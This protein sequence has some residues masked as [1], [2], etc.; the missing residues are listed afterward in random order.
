M[1]QFI[2]A[3][4]GRTHIVHNNDLDTLERGILE[5]VI[6]RKVDNELLPPMEPLIDVMSAGRKFRE[7]CCKRIS[8]L[9]PWTH[10][11]VVDAMG[12]K[13]KTYQHHLDNLKLR[14]LTRSDAKQT[15]F[16]KA[17]PLDLKFKVVEDLKPRIIRT[18]TVEFHISLGAYI[19]SCEKKI[20]GAINHVCGGIT[21]T[22]GLNAEETAEAIVAAFNSF[23]NPVCI[24]LDA[25][26]A[27]QSFRQRARAYVTSWYQKC[28]GS[29]PELMR[30]EQWRAEEQTIYANTEEG[31]LKA[32]GMFGMASGD[33]DTSLAMCIMIVMMAWTLLQDNNIRGRIIDNGDDHILFCDRAD[34]E[35]IVTQVTGHYRNFGFKLKCGE[36][37]FEIQKIEFCQSYPCF[38]GDKWI[39]MR[40]PRK[41]ISKDLISLKRIESQ[42]DFDYYRKAKSDCGLA[43]A[44]DLPIFGSFYRMLGRGTAVKVTPDLLPT[45]GMEFMARGLSRGARPV[46]T[47]SRVSFYKTF[48]VTPGEQIAIEDYYDSITPN[49][50]KPTSVESFNFNTSINTLL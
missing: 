27:D 40:D 32:K 43:M 11:Q 24:V 28:F 13:R 20:Y 14:D 45:S 3:G 29:D 30:L 15:M 2:P 19:K 44:G 22:K 41:S 17:E 9:T 35:T 18:R 47:E 36:P 7:K 5:R 46:T 25:S 4:N 31:R 12:Q 26:H 23:N 49:Y 21:V 38:D 42:K 33:K 48:D 50:L 16:T 6:G 8:R 37:V 1:V 39:M 34:L 10:Q